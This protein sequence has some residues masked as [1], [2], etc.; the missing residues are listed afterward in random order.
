MV[1]AQKLARVRPARVRPEVDKKGI[2]PTGACWGKSP[3]GSGGVQPA[4]EVSGREG[5][6]LGG[7]IGLFHE[8]SVSDGPLSEGREIPGKVDGCLRFFAARTRGRCQVV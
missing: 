5:R 7:P 3:R 8:Q 1:R 6:D 4:R 2:L